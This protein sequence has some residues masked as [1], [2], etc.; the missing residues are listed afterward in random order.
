MQL[1]RKL[2]E[3]FLSDGWIKTYILSE[4]MVIDADLCNF[5]SAKPYF[6]QSAKTGPTHQRTPMNSDKKSGC[7]G[8]FS[9]AFQPL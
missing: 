5:G 6:F 1:C 3:V 7:V 9:G 4:K 8:H 2:C